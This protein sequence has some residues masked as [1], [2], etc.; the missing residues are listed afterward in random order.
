MSDTVRLN[1]VDMSRWGGPLSVD[2]AELMLDAGVRLCIVG[3]GHPGGAGMYAR[4]QAETWLERATARGLRGRLDAYIYLYFGGDAERQVA[5][6]MGVLGGLPVGTWWAD[7]EDTD[8]PG[9][10]QD[11]RRAFLWRALRAIEGRGARAGIYTGAWWWRPNM[12]PST[13]FGQYPLWDSYYPA[14]DQPIVSPRVQ[15]WQGRGYGGFGEPE[16]YQ[17]HGTIDLG[18]QSVDLNWWRLEP[19]EDDVTR[20]EYEDLALALFAGSEQMSVRS[21]REERVA[22]ALAKVAEVAAGNEPSVAELGVAYP[23][24]GGTGIP[25]GTRLSVEVL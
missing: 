15:P 23:Q 13:K 12:G 6:G 9:L 24:I 20:T 18:G 3:T 19:E 5:D 22:Y 7:A 4:Q 11:E 8:S 17:Y 25:R 2:E 1:A 14:N 16:I 10:R 21:T